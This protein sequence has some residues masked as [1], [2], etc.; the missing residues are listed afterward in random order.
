MEA[1][2]DKCKKRGKDWDSGKSEVPIVA[3]KSG[4][5]DGAKGRRF[6]ITSWGNMARHRADCTMTTKLTRFTLKVREQPTLQ[7]TALM[8]L[9]CEEEGLRASFNSQPG[10]KAVGVDKVRGKK[11]LPKTQV[12]DL[13]WEPY[14]VTLQVRFCE[15]PAP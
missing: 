13:S 8:G 6:K 15:G 11:P 3:V 7:C 5:A 14:G 2:L 1:V 4:N 9:L 10:N 12:D